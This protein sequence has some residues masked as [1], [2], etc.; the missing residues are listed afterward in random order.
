MVHYMVILYQDQ[1]QPNFQNQAH[2]V[3]HPTEEVNRRIEHLSSGEMK[4]F[5]I[6][7]YNDSLMAV[8]SLLMTHT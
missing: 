4:I 2:L 3:A 5:I 7:T 1:K 6:S 8:D